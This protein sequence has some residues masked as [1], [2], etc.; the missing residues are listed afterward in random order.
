M[1]NM[2]LKQT[3]LL[4]LF[5]ICVANLIGGYVVLHMGKGM[6]FFYNQLL[7]NAPLPFLTEC[8]LSFSWWPFI[9][10]FFS[11]LIGIYLKQKS[12]E[13]KLLIN[14][15]FIVIYIDLF[16]SFLTLYSYIYPFLLVTY[17]LNG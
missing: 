8:T 3:Y 12:F 16:M 14:I 7:E 9:I 4:H 10:S 15:I 2:T 1:K 17:K 5:F 13:D 11:I 6:R